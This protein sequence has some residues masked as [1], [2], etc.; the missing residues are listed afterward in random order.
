[1]NQAS[2]TPR[3]HHGHVLYDADCAL[4]T[5]QVRLV[6]PLLR[7]H[8]FDLL[9]LQSPWARERLRGSGKDLLAE[10][11]LVTPAGAIFGG[12]DAL[13]EIARVIPWA[14]PFAWLARV[15]GIL[16]LLRRGY[17]CV[18]SRRHC[19]ALNPSPSRNP[20]ASTPRSSRSRR[21]FFESP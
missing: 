21:V 9:P 11:R 19:A 1:M 20:T 3:S 18:A 7:R 6:E 10:L 14:R 4:C 16:P 5:R 2:P 12:A 17:A 15:P 13:V 8:G